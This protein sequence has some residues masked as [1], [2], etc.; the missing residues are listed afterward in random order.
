[1]AF[2]GPAIGV[3]GQDLPSVPVEFR[4]VEQVVRSLALEITRQ[5]DIQETLTTRL[6]IEGLLAF[7][8]QAGME[9]KLIEVEFGP[10]LGRIVRPGGHTGQTV[11]FFAGRAFALGGAWR[12][13]SVER[14]LGVNM[15]D[16][17]NV[18]GQFRQDALAAVGA[19]SADEDVVVRKP[20]GNQG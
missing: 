7:D 16:Q 8:G 14:T 11:A 12:S 10:R 2:D 15:A 19:V 1:D 5:D 9:A 3:G 17:V 6:V 4:A 18:G 13:R 20:R